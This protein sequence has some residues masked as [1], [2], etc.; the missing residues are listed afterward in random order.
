MTFGMVNSH[1]LHMRSTQMEK[2][3][4]AETWG[5]IKTV[6]WLEEFEHDNR[7]VVVFVSFLYFVVT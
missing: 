1:A 4:S 7:F 6:N 5:I 2:L 3:Q